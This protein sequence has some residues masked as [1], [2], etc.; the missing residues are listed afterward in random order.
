MRNLLEV[1]DR[2]LEVVPDKRSWKSLR[3]QLKDVKAS[4]SLSSPELMG[5]WWSECAEVLNCS[6]P[7]ARTDWQQKIVRIC[8]GQE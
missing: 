5:E 8:G 4:A 1:I 6:I 3:D 2:I 7:Q